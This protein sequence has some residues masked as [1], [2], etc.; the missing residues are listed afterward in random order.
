M[1]YVCAKHWARPDRLKALYP[2]LFKDIDFKELYDQTLSSP[3]LMD[4]QA[5]GMDTGFYQG[6]NQS[7][8]PDF[9][10]VQYRVQKKSIA[11]STRT[12]ITLKHSMKKKPKAGSV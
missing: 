9:I 5:G 3:E 8:N 1:K 4:R 6:Y 12:T 7:Q 2:H 10:E 11:G